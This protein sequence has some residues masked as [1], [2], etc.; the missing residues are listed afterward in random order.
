VGVIVLSAVFLLTVAFGAAVA[1]GILT[2]VLH[3]VVDGELAR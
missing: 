2:L 3:L 1:K